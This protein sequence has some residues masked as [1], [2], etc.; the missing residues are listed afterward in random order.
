MKL[1]I[2]CWMKLMKELNRRDY[3]CMHTANKR[4]KITYC[5][6]RKTVLLLESK[7]FLTTKKVGRSKIIS[8]TSKGRLVGDKVSNIIPF[9]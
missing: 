4:A 9:I 2:P 7:G 6:L 8:L 3:V 5:H 1:V